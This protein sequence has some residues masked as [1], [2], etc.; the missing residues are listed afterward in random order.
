[1]DKPNYAMTFG[2]SEVAR[3]L[4]V[5][6]DLVKKW[7]CLFC[8][9]LKPKANPPKGSPR[10]F[11]AADLRVLGYIYMYW[12]DDT[13]LESIRYGLNTGGHYEDKYDRFITSVTPLFQGPPEDL[14]EDWRHGAIVG[15]M[16]EHGDTFALA[17]SYKLAG[18][19]LVDV[20]LTKDEAF[21]LICPVVYNYRHATELYLK[22]TIVPWEKTHRLIGLLEEFKKVLKSE[23]DATI[24][25]WFENIIIAF[26]DFDPNGTAFR[27][28]DSGALLR[29]GE[30]WID[31]VHIKTVM[32]WMAESCQKIR[33][34][35]GMI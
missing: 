30:V 24:P 33:Q 6:R 9:Y 21:D 26:N 25:A 12:E 22:A 18:D 10:L 31:I 1:M 34:R 17:D 15:G 29:Y 14:D 19:I 5:D 3:I 20:A 7:A 23:F 28:G 8:D 4:E 35:R 32:G 2:L 27:Y 11:C 13:D 16:A